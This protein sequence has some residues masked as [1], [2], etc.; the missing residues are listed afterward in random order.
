MDTI[1][2]AANSAHETVDKIANATNQAAEALGEKGEQL[3]NCEQQLV[4]NCRSYVH[5][6]PLTA[7][8]IAAA[9]GFVLSRLLS[10][11]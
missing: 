3:K 7:L 11:R 8:G 6:N 2:N 5:E 1:K 4:E 9:A 10:S